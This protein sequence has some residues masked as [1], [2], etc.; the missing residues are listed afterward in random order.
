MVHKIFL[1]AYINFAFMYR[2]DHIVLVLTIKD[3]INEYGE[4]T[5]TFK[6]VTGTKTSVSHLRVLLFP[7]VVQ[8]ATAHVGTKVLNMHHQEQK[9]F[10][11]Y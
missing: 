1:E 5:M 6:L 9:G 8:K 4:P 10:A 7:C 2:V 11:V 3:L